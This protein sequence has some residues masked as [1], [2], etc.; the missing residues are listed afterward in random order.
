MSVLSHKINVQAT[1]GQNERIND[2]NLRRIILLTG[3]KLKLGES[4]E[5]TCTVQVALTFYDLLIAAGKVSG[6]AAIV[7]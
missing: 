5:W 3:Q 4:G 7:P 6:A 1:V 2:V